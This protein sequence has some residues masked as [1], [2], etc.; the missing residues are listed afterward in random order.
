MGSLGH[1]GMGGKAEIVICTEIQDF[2]P[3]HNDFGSLLTADNPF[4][5][6]KPGFPDLIQLGADTI[7]K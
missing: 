3:V 5:F 1:L 2:A 7:H 6:K 4:G